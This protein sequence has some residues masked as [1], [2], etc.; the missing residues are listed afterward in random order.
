MEFVEVNAGNVDGQ[1]FFCYMSKRKAEGYQ[2]K[3]SWVKE[4]FSE[5]MRLE[6]L[7]PPERGFVEYLPGEH[8]WRSVYAEGYLF[9]HCLWVVGKSKGKGFGVA[10]LNE[11]VGEAK[12]LGMRGVAM[13]TSENVWVAGRRLLASQGFEC[14]D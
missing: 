1:G 7:A 5:G 9:I 4:R 6:L 13:V 3:L 8:A 10:L 12:R 11:C 2:R 14:V